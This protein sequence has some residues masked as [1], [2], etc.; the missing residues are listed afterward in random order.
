MLK[1]T[2]KDGS[3]REVAEGTS[4][5]DFVKQVSNSLA[6]KVLAAKVDGQTR[7]LMSVLDKDAQVEFL[8]FTRTARCS[9][10]SALPLKTGFTMISI[11]SV[12]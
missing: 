1:I 2:L 11:W 10:L 3:V 4:I 6:K 7:D 9:W 12:S 5:L 8:T